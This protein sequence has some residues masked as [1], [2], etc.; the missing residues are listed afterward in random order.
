MAPAHVLRAA[1]DDA[2]GVARANSLA[3]KRHGLEAGAAHL[4][5]GEC[6]DRVRQ[7]RA[8]GCLPR[9][10]LPRARPARRSREHFVD[11]RGRDAG[12]AHGSATTIEPSF[13]AGTE[14]SS[15]SSLP[16]GVR[17]PARIKASDIKLLL[18]VAMFVLNSLMRRRVGAGVWLARICAW[19]C[20]P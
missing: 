8:K 1:G 3:G 16:I 6:G 11:L 9:G 17:Q 14:E 13:V 5:D 2:G 15:P 19:R 12:A 20:P 7:A 10:G 4:V 18:G